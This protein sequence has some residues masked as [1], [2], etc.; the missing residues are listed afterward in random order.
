M[1]IISLLDAK[2]RTMSFVQVLKTLILF[3][4]LVAIVIPLRYGSTNP[5]YLIIRLLHSALSLKHP[6]ISDPLR[7]EVSDEYRAFENL[8]RLRS[9]SKPDPSADALPLIKK[10]RSKFLLRTLLPKP[11]QC[12]VKKEIFE[13]DGHTVDTYWVHHRQVSSTPKEVDHILIYLHGGGFIMGDIEG[14]LT[15]IFLM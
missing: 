6:F 7:P 10:I 14:M 12:Q 1:F 11:S 8:F 13:Y 4:A 3:I 2:I 15:I 5:K 9:V